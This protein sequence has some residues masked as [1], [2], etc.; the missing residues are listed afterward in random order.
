MHEQERPPIIIAKGIFR[1]LRSFYLTILEV[2]DDEII[3]KLVLGDFFS[4]ERRLKRDAQLA[5]LVRRLK[6]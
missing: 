4:R 6:Y 5:R 3:H 2:F 1:L